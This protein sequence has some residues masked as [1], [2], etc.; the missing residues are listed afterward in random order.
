[1]N[2]PEAQYTAFVVPLPYY[3]LLNILYHDYGNAYFSAVLLNVYRDISEQDLSTSVVQNRRI[4][5]NIKLLEM[6]LSE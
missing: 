2:Y 1:M 6:H 5:L 3:D 4:A